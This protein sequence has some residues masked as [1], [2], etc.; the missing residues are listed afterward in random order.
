MGC[1]LWVAEQWIAHGPRPSR[2]WIPELAVPGDVLRSIAV[3]GV[4]YMQLSDVSRSQCGEPKP[5]QSH[6]VGQ[7]VPSTMAPGAMAQASAIEDRG[8]SAAK[9]RVTA[10]QCPMNRGKPS[11]PPKTVCHLAQVQSIGGLFLDATIDTHFL[12]ATVGQPPGQRP[13]H[14]SAPCWLACRQGA[15]QE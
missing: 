10:F 8:P 4:P 12:Y 15:S 7:G 14:C 5:K 1:R 11:L 13:F 3:V 9:H 2:P 6:C